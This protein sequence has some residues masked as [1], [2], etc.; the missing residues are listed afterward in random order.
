MGS[1]NVH[2]IS[3]F[4]NELFQ[5][6]AHVTTVVLTI[7]SFSKFNPDHRKPILVF[8]ALFKAL[9]SMRFCCEILSI[10]VHHQLSRYHT[11]D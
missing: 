6:V 5:N 9:S 7:P 10:L 2:L 8:M 3:G 11:A 4:T 1:I